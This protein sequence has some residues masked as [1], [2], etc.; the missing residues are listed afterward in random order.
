MFK[1]GTTGGKS[2]TGKSK[3]FMITVY[4]NG[5]PLYRLITKNKNEMNKAISVIEGIA[6]KIGSEIVIEKQKV[7]PSK[8]VGYMNKSESCK[9]GQK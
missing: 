3:Q 5:Q 6:A 4:E 2:M 8:Y 1:Y 9:L 7:Y